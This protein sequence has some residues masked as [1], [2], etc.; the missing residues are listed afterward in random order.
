MLMVAMAVVSALAWVQV[1]VQ[2]ELPDKA[3]MVVAQVPMVKAKATQEASPVPVQ[4][5]DQLV[6]LP[7]QALGC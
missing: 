3:A 2:L 4:L 5:V 1:L 7:E 6:H